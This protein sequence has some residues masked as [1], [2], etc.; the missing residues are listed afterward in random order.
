MAFSKFHFGK[1]LLASYLSVIYTYI[2][3]SIE[4]IVQSSIS[5]CTVRSNKRFISDFYLIQFSWFYFRNL[6]FRG[7]FSM[8][9]WSIFSIYRIENKIQ[10]SI[11]ID[12]LNWKWYFR[13]FILVQFAW[14]AVYL[15]ICWYSKQFYS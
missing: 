5:E 14:S 8:Y 6:L 12:E 4:L 10:F 15:L 1:V 3:Y 13:S 2:K 11:Q 9:I 7:I